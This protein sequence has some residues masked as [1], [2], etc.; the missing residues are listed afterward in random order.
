MLHIFRVVSAVQMGNRKEVYSDQEIGHMAKPPTY[1]L[2]QYYPSGIV[3]SRCLFCTKCTREVD[4]A[5][6]HKTNVSYSTHTYL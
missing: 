1:H 3:S 2:G 4:E 6:P 5:Q